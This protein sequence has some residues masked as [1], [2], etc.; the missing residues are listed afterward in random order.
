MDI[1][2]ILEIA[3][4]QR[5]YIDPTFHYQPP[6]YF[7]LDTEHNV[8]ALG[9]LRKA[10]SQTD[11]DM[12]V[13]EMG[14][15]T[16]VIPN[17]GELAIVLD[18]ILQINQNDQLEFVAKDDP[19]NLYSLI[20][21]NF[22]PDP[23]EPTPKVILSPYIRNDDGTIQFTPPT[24]TLAPH[25]EEAI[26]DFIHFHQELWTHNEPFPLTLTELL[27]ILTEGGHLIETHL[28]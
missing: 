21:F 24:H 5:R 11:T 25:S 23:T 20:L 16:R 7:F 4:E 3:Q 28:T 8:T 17:I 13:T 22:G 6:M 12:A 10:E 27:F 1:K 26:T 14:A 15:L 19:N 9:I 2:S 18:T